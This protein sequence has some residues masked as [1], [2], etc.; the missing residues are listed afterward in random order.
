MAAAALLLVIA[1]ALV[2][3]KSKVAPRVPTKS[4]AAAAVVAA[5]VL[6]IYP[7]AALAT[8]GMLVLWLVGLLPGAW[9]KKV[10]AF[11]LSLAV[12][13]GDS[14]ALISSPRRKRAMFDA[15]TK[16]AEELLNALDAE[17]TRKPLVILAHSQGAALIYRL[18]YDPDFTRLLEDR[19]VTLVTHG[20]AIVPIHVLE[21]RHRGDQRR[22]AGWGV[23]GVLGLALLV[24]TLGRIAASVLN[25]TVALTTAVSVA[26]VGGSLWAARRDERETSCSDLLEPPPGKKD[27]GEETDVD[28]GLISRLLKGIWGPPEQRF[29]KASAREPT[30]VGPAVPVGDP[31]RT[32]AAQERPPA[33]SATG[34]TGYTGTGDKGGPQKVCPR[35]PIPNGTR[36]R[37]VDIWA[38]W[39]PVPNGPIDIRRPHLGDPFKPLPASES[40]FIPCRVANN[41]QP[42]S[43]HIVYRTNDEEVVSRWIGEIAYRAD[44]V[45]TPSAVEPPNATR[46]ARVRRLVIGVLL[47]VMQGLVLGA[48]LAAMVRRWTQLDDLGRWAVRTFPSPVRTALGTAVD[49]V[50]EQVRNLLFGRDHDPSQLQGFLLGLAA[51]AI[52]IILVAAV[53]SQWRD[54][55]SAR[56]RAKQESRD[57]AIVA[58]AIV[59]F[60]VFAALVGAA[61][62]VAAS[63]EA[64]ME[65][66]VY[67]VHL[68]VDGAAGAR[69]VL[70]FQP[71]GKDAEA[72][73]EV[74]VGS[75]A[76]EVR[77]DEKLR[78]VVTAKADGGKDCTVTTQGLTVTAS[79]K[80]A[81][82][83]MPRD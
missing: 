75:D 2:P 50:P 51:T 35:L 48:G 27:G 39:D 73:V 29:A 67:T 54:A 18:F 1:L 82:P 9:S 20:G 14:Y 72:K 21:A 65:S 76:E 31:E 52:A 71:V 41:H 6:V 61:L 19:A 78:Y 3:T 28:T 36:L 79:C 45:V 11:Q 8:G 33:G 66:R 34:G 38:P 16:A 40:A 60:A 13:V 17:G 69:G 30:H 55:R 32:R 46:V 42:W 77:L 49:V 7:L 80:A 62:W 37:W 22:W 53:A 24:V 56:F 4:R 10:R 47:L 15:I 70:M 43:D 25:V 12:S 64:G 57:V 26:L 44:Q 63:P 23:A 59:T 83:V 68:T 74:E 81:G 5:T 58:S